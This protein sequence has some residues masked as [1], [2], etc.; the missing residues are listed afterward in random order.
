MYSW[1]NQSKQSVIMLLLCQ[2][3]YLCLFPVYYSFLGCFFFLAEGVIHRVRR[4]SGRRIGRRGVVVT[5]RVQAK[6]R[7]SG[8]GGGGF[9][10]WWALSNETEDQ[11]CL[12]GTTNCFT[13]VRGT[14]PEE[15]TQ[16]E[17]GFER[18]IDGVGGVFLIYLLQN[19][20]NAHAA[21]FFDKLIG[22]YV[23]DVLLPTELFADIDS[24]S[25]K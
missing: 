7:G 5:S 10:V 13:I 12:F 1:C 2:C 25:R 16:Y 15:W 17:L 20:N 19:I 8:G 23:G 18:G 4:P 11:R 14:R 22:C 21:L 9:H 24:T 3:L 6:E